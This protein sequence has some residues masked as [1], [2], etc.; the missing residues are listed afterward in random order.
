[1]QQISA[2]AQEKAPHADGAGRQLPDTAYR[3]LIKLDADYL[4]ADSQRLRLVPG[5]LV[6]AEVHVGRR[7]V[8]EYVLS[9]IQKVAFEAGRER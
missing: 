5:M 8:L 4:Q 6:T 7:S 9:P 2:D 1:V 3:A